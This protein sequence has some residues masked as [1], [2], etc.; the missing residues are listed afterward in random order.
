MS[1]FK[2]PK[3]ICKA[4]A[5]A[6]ARFWWG[7]KEGK[8]AMHWYSWW[9]MCTPK[10]EGGMGFRDLHCFNLAMLS[11]QV[12]RLIV[13]PE[14]LCAQILR[15][16][17][18]PS[19]NILTA[20]L[21]KGASFT[22]QSLMA[23]MNTFKRGYIW[24][25]GNGSSINV[26][27]DP[28]LPNSPNRRVFSRQNSTLIGKVEE[29]IDP[30]TGSWDVQLLQ[31]IFCPTDVRMI[32]AIP[33]SPWMEE[34]SIAWHGNRNGMFSVRS[35]YHME[36]QHQYGSRAR[37]REAGNSEIN[38]VWEVCWK[39]SVPAKVKIFTWRALHGI[40]PCMCVLAN[41]HIGGSGQCPVCEWGAE[42]VAHMMFKCDRSKEVWKALGIYPIIEKAANEDRSGSVVLEILLRSKHPTSPM[43]GGLGMK[44]IIATAA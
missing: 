30:G 2:L 42:D 24:R 7:E 18:Y 31:E 16:K 21:K 5:A 35:A 39:L 43:L 3:G 8:K 29:L 28:W 41:K 15:A 13:A 17:Y 9:K 6:I 14:S 44:E 38:P 26:W 10:K 4:I 33:L 34:D 23:G 20:E 27:R 22:W 32:T 40:I 37:R 12:W 19:G 1:V 25:V 11:K 36:W